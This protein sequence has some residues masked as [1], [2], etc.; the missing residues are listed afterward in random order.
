MFE[1]RDDTIIEMFEEALNQLAL[2]PSTI[3]NYL[4]DLRTFLRWGQC[5]IDT[6]FSL[7]VVNQAHIR[8]YRHYLT[9]QMGR[10]T[11]T[12]NR[13]MMALRKFFAFALEMDLISLDPMS[14]IALVH[15]SGPTDTQP[16]AADDAEKLIIA[17]KK[18][19]RGSLVRRDVAILELLLHTGLRVGEVV[20]LKK[21][22]VVFN[23]PG[24]SLRVCDKRDETKVRY[25]PL[26]QKIYKALNE[27]L[28]V[29]PQAASTDHLFLTQRGQPIS[30]R[31]VQ[32]I[33]SDCAKMANL[34]GVSAQVLRR[35]FAWQLFTATHDLALV[36][37]LLGHQSKAITAQY[38]MVQD[39][40]SVETEMRA[41]G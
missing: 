36:S 4:A 32:R 39:F 25:L 31:T 19:S 38:L 37:D 2:S 16:L 7:V 12:I 17:A 30:E 9:H 34:T 41:K 40:T 28:A 3:V 26:S 5:E 20:S 23:S 24:V 33:I 18:G 35:T 29:R 27:Y 15:D 10:A 1:S 22:D 13:H 6:E 11:S 8:T 14:G 21:E